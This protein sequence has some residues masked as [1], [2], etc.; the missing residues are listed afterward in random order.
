ML[1]N[2]IFVSLSGIGILTIAPSSKMGLGLPP[3]VVSKPLRLNT[4]RR[5]HSSETRLIEPLLGTCTVAHCNARNSATLHRFLDPLVRLL[6]CFRQ[7]SAFCNRSHNVRIPHP[8][9]QNVH[10]YVPRHPGPGGAANIH[11]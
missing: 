5:G 8:A 4:M 3:A 10:V 7:H 1:S 11:A 2:K 9:R 6:Q